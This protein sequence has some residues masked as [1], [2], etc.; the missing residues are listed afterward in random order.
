MAINTVSVVL[1]H[2]TS[3]YAKIEEEIVKPRTVERAFIQVI[4]VMCVT[5]QTEHIAGA[6]EPC[7]QINGRSHEWWQA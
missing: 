6:W 3:R 1:E 5:V 2:F 7:P 4:S